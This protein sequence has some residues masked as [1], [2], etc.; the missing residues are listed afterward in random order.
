MKNE[1]IETKEMIQ[2]DLMDGEEERR[3]QY[4]PV[5]KLFPHPDNPRKELGDLTELTDSIRAKGVMQNLTVVPFVSKVNPKFNGA[6]LYTVIIGHRRCAAAKLAGLTELPCVVV[7]MTPEEQVATM[8][9]ENM[10]RVDLT[11]FEQAQGFQMMLDLGDSVTGIAEKTGFSK[12]TVRRRL[13]L[14]ELDQ[15][16]LQEASGRQVSLLDLERLE[17]IEDVKERNRVLKSIGTN[18]FERDLAIALTDQKNKKLEA[19]CRAILAEYNAIEIPSKD[20]WDNDKYRSYG[21][22]DIGMP[23]KLREDLERLKQQKIYF[24]I[25]YGSCYLRT[26]AGAKD[27]KEEEEKLAKQKAEDERNMRRKALTEAFE[28]AYDLR[29]G[30]IKKLASGRGSLLSDQASDFIIKYSCLISPEFDPVFFF[31]IDRTNGR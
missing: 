9:L 1:T 29:T 20:K 15:K 21:Y 31:G 16:L 18:N 11:P 13:K 17:K 4:I 25:E 22:V 12:S 28:R 27:Q 26:P 23:D 30:Y 6:G 3:L 7:E 2:C 10:Q 8:L 5:D 14:T 24:C 19:A